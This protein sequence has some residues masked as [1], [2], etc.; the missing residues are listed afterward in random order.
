MKKLIS[1][2]IPAYNEEDCIEELSNRLELLIQ[3]ENNY[4]WEIFIVEN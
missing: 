3:K 4:M 1:V 2:G